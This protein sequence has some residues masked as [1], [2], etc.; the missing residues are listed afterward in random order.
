M[1]V[2]IIAFDPPVLLCNG[3]ALHV[4]LL[5]LQ[6]VTRRMLILQGF[7]SKDHQ[8]L[9]L[10]HIFSKPLYNKKIPKYILIYISCYLTR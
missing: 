9:R 8:I 6:N 4:T 2:K 7:I 1:P 5:F 10:L 3:K